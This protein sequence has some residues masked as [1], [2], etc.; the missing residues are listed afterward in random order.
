MDANII[1][2]E[3]LKLDF[4]DEAH[5]LVREV[6]GNMSWVQF[7][8]YKAKYHLPLVQ[9]FYSNMKTSNDFTNKSHVGGREVM[10]ISEKL[11]DILGLPVLKPIVTLHE[12]LLSWPFNKL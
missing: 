8:R 3:V 11:H 12:K 10:I 9:V 6:L 1:K 4:F 7:C 5:L 2:L